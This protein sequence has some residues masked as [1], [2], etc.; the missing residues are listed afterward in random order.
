MTSAMCRA[1]VAAV[2]IPL[3]VM[4]ATAAWMAPA[5]ANPIAQTKSDFVD[6]FRQLDEDWP[7]PN[8]YRTASGAPGHAYWQQ[9]VDYRI[10]AELDDEHQQIRGSQSITYRN[11]SPD[12]LRYLWVQLDQNRYEKNSDEFLLNTSG[13]DSRM[14]FRTLEGLLT[15][16]T[17]G[18]GYK[19]KSVTDA[20]G[21]AL[22]TAVNRTMMRIDLDEPLGPGETTELRIAWS[23]RIVDGDAYESDSG[24]RYYPKDRNYIY[25]I[26]QWF[27]R[28]AAYT[29]VNGW[30]HRQTL[31]EGE[32]TLEFGNFDVA[33]TV[34]ADHIVVGTGELQNPQAVLTAAQRERLGRAASAEQPVMI[35]TEQEARARQGGHS[36]EKKTWRFQASNV[37]DFA[38]GSSRK[39]MWDAWGQRQKSGRTVMAQSFYPVEGVGLWDRYVTQGIAQTLET[40]SRFFGEY[41]YSAASVVSGPWSIGDV[42]SA[43]LA[44]VS[45]FFP[46]GER[47]LY[48]EKDK[49]GLL[50]LV[51]RQVGH[52]WFPAI[53]NTNERQWVWMDD[54]MVSFFDSIVLEDW[55]KGIGLRRKGLH[56]EEFRNIL[57]E[58]TAADQVPLMS[59]ARV[60]LLHDSGISHAKFATAMTVLRETVLGRELFDFAIGE[61][62]RRWQFKRPEPADF[63]RT[64]EDAAGMDL[65]WFWR[66]WFYSTDHVDLAI[67]QVTRHRLNT[68]DPDV[69]IAWRRAQHQAQPERLT[70]LR[71]AAAP[72]RDRRY[73]ALRDFYSDHDDEFTVTDRQ[74][75]EYHELLASLSPERKALLKRTEQFYLVEFANL[76]GLVMPLLVQ[77]EYE[78]GS[79]EDRR[80]PAEI[81]Q[82]DP[83]SVAQIFISDKPIRSIQLDPHLE[84]A[85]TDMSNNRFP[86]VAEERRL[87]LFDEFVEGRKRGSRNL[88]QEVQ[89]RRTGPQTR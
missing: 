85:D 14:S 84:T 43:Q 1:A 18:A 62:V 41:P 28:M 76:G 32:Y 31:G 86:R 57:T 82:G 34:P 50:T 33:I 2:L 37:R 77:I 15:S 8:D 26:G 87:E 64:M 52:N 44:F 35:V 19:L 67:Q 46:E 59:D 60:V 79:R 16:D 10:E 63:F 3:C 65:D 73:P 72:A 80:F 27:P 4:A 88:M 36:K 70:T 9:Q 20:A 75:N 54:S 11:N 68:G 58:M 24:L 23:F 48:S 51:S 78:D 69:E 40:Y 53:V 45:Y 42:E 61:Y 74:R 71:D 5:Q 25:C 7:T 83:K 29:D 13:T 49:Y 30:A 89:E 39:F 22:R 66:G 38:F 81:W 17:Y 55:E 12:T 56:S 21:K 6:K 47:R